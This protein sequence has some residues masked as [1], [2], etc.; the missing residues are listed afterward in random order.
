MTL[1]EI[2][3]ALRKRW[4]LVVLVPAIVLPALI[5]RART[6]PFQTSLNAVV[7]IPGDTE[8]P[9]NSERPELMVLDDLPSLISSRV[10]A[11][12]VAQDIVARAGNA[13][14]ASEV[15]GIQAALGATRYSRVLTITVTRDDRDAVATIAASAAAV[16]PAMVN[17]YLVADQAEPATVQIIDPPGMPSRARPNQ[18]LIIAAM[19]VVALAAGAG[20]A[21]T[22]EAL[23]RAWTLPGARSRPTDPPDD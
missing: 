13:E 12:A 3:D 23:E 2:V 1:R 21:L 22:A 8:D 9:G 15:E 14:L 10:F 19:T 5:V 20:I 6:Q 18:A 16:L 4:W 17:R 11:E 7:L